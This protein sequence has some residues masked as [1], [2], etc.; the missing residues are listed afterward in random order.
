MHELGLVSHV[1]KTIEDLCEEQDLSQVSSVTLQIGEVSGIIPEY[2]DD[3]WKWSVEKTEKMK[4]CELK[5][6]QLKAVTYC[7]TCG[8]KYETVKYAKICPDCGSDNTYLLCGNE[9]I[10][11]EIEAC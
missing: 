11:K 1:I 5:W 4:G 6:E 3:C 2:L 9:F 7:E 8:S 10:I